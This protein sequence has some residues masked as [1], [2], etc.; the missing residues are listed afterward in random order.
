MKSG[1]RKKTIFYRRM[2]ETL[3]NVKIFQGLL[4]SPF[5]D[6]K[7]LPF[8]KNIQFTEAVWQIKDTRSNIGH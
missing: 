1:T 7:L 2:K 8:V 3:N 5:L 4:S 6:F